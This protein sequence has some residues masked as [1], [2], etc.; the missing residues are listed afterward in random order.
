VT[1]PTNNLGSSTGS[2]EVATLTTP[3]RIHWCDGSAEEYDELCQLLVDNGTFTKLSEAKRPNS[4]YAN[5]DPGDV[6]RVE[7]RTYICSQKEV[8]AGPTNNWRRARGHAHPP[9]RTVRVGR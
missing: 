2:N 7:D 5:R 6:A 9:E 8:D 3:D 4:Y 1:Y